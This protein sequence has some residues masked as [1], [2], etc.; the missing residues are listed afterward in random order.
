[1]WLS[2]GPA[3]TNWFH[4][5]F[6]SGTLYERTIHPSK[7]ATP[8]E[9]NNYAGKTVLITGG[10]GSL[11]WSLVNRFLETDIR[12]IIIYSRDEFKQYRMEKHFASN[13]DRLRF[14]IGDVRDRD[15]LHRA[16]SG[17]DIV[18]HAAALKHVHLM[19]YNPIEAVNTNILGARNIIDAAIDRGVEKVVALSTDKAVNPINIYGATKLVSDKLFRSAHAYS[20]GS[21]PSFT[22]VRY[23]NVVGSR[24]SVIPFFRDLKQQKA[25]LLPITDM[26]MT[27][28]FITMQESVELVMKAL[29][30]GLGGELFISRIPSCSIVDLATAI[31]PE[32]KLHETGIRPGEKLHEVLL[33]EDEARNTYDYGEHFVVYPLNFQSMHKSEIRP[34]G[35]PVPKEFCF[36]SETNANWLDVEALRKLVSD[37][38]DHGDKLPPFIPGGGY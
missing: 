3:A 2:N 10:T 23:G 14:F 38:P 22:V 26:R 5:F 27:R 19:E 9:S 16:F 12:R 25:P 4:F 31:Y 1:M 36:S 28:F 30:L 15:R 32:A 13:R 8:L 17:V 21:G 29:K 33:T 24:G 35:K 18:I 11:G 20:G 34:G 7:D 37:L 6:F